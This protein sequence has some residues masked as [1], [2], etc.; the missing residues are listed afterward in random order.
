MTTQI[1]D[2]WEL[3][4]HL[5]GDLIPM[6]KYRGRGVTA[7]TEEA[8]RDADVITHPKWRIRRG[9]TSFKPDPVDSAF[10]DWSFLSDVE[11]YDPAMHGMHEPAEM[12]SQ[13]SLDALEKS[14]FEPLEIGVWHR[15]V[16]TSTGENLGA[17]HLIM[18]SPG[19]RRPTDGT[20]AP[21]HL[22][23]DPETAGVAFSTL[24]GPRGAISAA[25]EDVRQ[26]RAGGLPKESARTPGQSSADDWLARNT[27]ESFSNE[28][29]MRA[30][31]GDPEHGYIHWDPHP[32]DYT[33]S[34][35]GDVAGQS[36]RGEE[37]QS[38]VMPGSHYDFGRGNWESGQPE[39]RREYVDHPYSSPSQEEQSAWDAAEQHALP[40]EMLP[41]RENWTA[42]DWQMFHYQPPQGG[43][44]H[45]WDDPGDEDRPTEDERSLLEGHGF[46]DLSSPGVYVRQ[47]HD[48]E[49]RHVATHVIRHDPN[50]DRWRLDTDRQHEHSEHHYANID[51][52]I[53]KYRDNAAFALL[54]RRGYH[55]EGNHWTR[56]DP[57]GYEHEIHFPE[58]GGFEGS[59]S[60]PTRS[61][62]DRWTQRSDHDL[63]DV[64][65]EQDHLGRGE[66][67]GGGRDFRLTRDELLNDPSVARLG[68]P[69]WVSD[70]F[71]GDGRVGSASWVL[72]HPD[73]PHRV[74]AEA[75]YDWGK[76]GYDF[77]YTQDG[78]PLAVTHNY[79]P[80]GAPV[81]VPGRQ[82]QLF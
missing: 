56:S 63:A 9:P 18:Y 60:G 41:H 76:G 71:H 22:M 28:D 70:D 78:I 12:Y 26:I 34:D 57:G 65:R 55:L 10:S 52:A 37:A 68:R 48:P 3:P 32:S 33:Y 82:S 13:E 42:R 11:P 21:W 36:F 2:S 54:P 61:P 1:A 16:T 46:D 73:T 62:H 67:P 24:R 64:V 35:F 25:D 4:S 14:G 43:R 40:G 6:R 44:P 81:H 29:W 49:G 75:T 27:D 30:R 38:H 15:P 58:W 79:V 53:D 51:D 77:R 59:T 20:R 17:S 39:P 23:T 80:E 45:V 7:P 5:A 31:E 72:S 74:H 19:H 66:H 8:E 47:Q 69:A 50:T